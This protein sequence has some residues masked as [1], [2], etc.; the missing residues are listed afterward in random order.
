LL[1]RLKQEI[2]QHPFLYRTACLIYNFLHP[3]CVGSF[4]WLRRQA[5]LPFYKDSR[6]MSM[7]TF[8]H[9]IDFFYQKGDREFHVGHYNNAIADW[10]ESHKYQQLV[11]ARLPEF[12]DEMVLLG[13]FWSNSIGH[14][15]LIEFPVKAV[16]LG[17]IPKKIIRLYQNSPDRLA[18]GYLLKCF[19]PMIEILPH[20]AIQDQRHEVKLNLAQQRINVL[21]YT[22]QLKFLY[23]FCYDVEQR[24][25]ES[26]NSNH[27][28]T[29]PVADYVS[30]VT[31]LAT[32]GLEADQ[33]FVVLHVRSPNYKKDNPN[34]VRNVPLNEYADAIE[35]L[36][37]ED[38]QV[39]FLGDR[40]VEVP[41][42]LK[43]KLIDYSD[44][45]IRSSMLDVFLCAHC[46]FFMGTSSGITHVPRLFGRPRLWT[47][48]SPFLSL[49]WFA[50]DMWIPKL[51]WDEHRKCHLN[52]LEMMQT[53]QVLLETHD[54]LRRHHLSIENN[55]AEDLLA[56]TRDM[57]AFVRDN[58][59]MPLPKKIQ[60]ALHEHHMPTDAVIAPSF[61]KKYHRIFDVIIEV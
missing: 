45:D 49:P 30:A 5:Y 4:I 39:V 34:S 12:A 52:L 44:S 8:M 54:L 7:K 56:A 37:G 60:K 26:G 43:G 9:Y 41:L 28:L 21:P 1:Y 27:L 24:W 11:R 61:L 57:L 32:L 14:T 38:V 33:P 15:S 3:L 55:C 53:P 50:E 25:R 47:N 29:F 51:M 42:K 31:Q 58:V 22:D 20:T 46:L 13:S 35:F 16:K 59:P 19:E 18:N 40:G 6:D 17:L 23:H 36:F 2:K 10:S 48:L